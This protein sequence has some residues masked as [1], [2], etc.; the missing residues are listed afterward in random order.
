VERLYQNG[1]PLHH[2]DSARAVHSDL[3]DGRSAFFVTTE[4]EFQKL[5][6]DQIQAIFRDRHIVI[7]GPPPDD[8]H[9]DHQGLAALGSLTASRQIQGMLYPIEQNDLSSKCAVGSLRMVEKPDNLL[10]LGT[11]K[12]LLAK[13]KQGKRRIL[14]VLDLPMGG[15]PVPMPPQYRWVIL[16]HLLL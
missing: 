3:L 11:L 10:R 4:A 14:N 12:D 8:F 2:L 9:F 5:K 1:R 16:P 13:D 7:P 6:G 15:A